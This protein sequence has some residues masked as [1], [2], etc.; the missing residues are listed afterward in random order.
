VGD[1]E[2]KEV[3]GRKDWMLGNSGFPVKVPAVIKIVREGAG[4]PARMYIDGKRFDCA[5]VDGFTVHPTRDSM[6][7]VMLTI[8]ASRVELVDDL[9]AKPGELWPAEDKSGGGQPASR[10]KPGGADGQ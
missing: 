3:T 10:M 4:K 9:D 6:P 5:T 7:C 8:V 2:A 1:P